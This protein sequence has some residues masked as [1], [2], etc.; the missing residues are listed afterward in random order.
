MFLISVS[1]AS[2]FAGNVFPVQTREMDR[3]SNKQKT[4]N[5]NRIET[6]P[7]TTVFF[8]VE[9]AKKTFFTDCFNKLDIVGDLLTD[10]CISN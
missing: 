2:G 8:D 9:S 5:M 10:H 4:K 6:A 7:M 3:N 1:S